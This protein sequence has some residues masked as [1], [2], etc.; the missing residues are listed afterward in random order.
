M[1]ITLYSYREAVS[2]DTHSGTMFISLLGIMS[3]W[4]LSVRED[5][6]ATGIKHYR[7]T[8]KTWGRR[9]EMSSEQEEKVISL[10]KKGLSLRNVS[11]KAGTSKTS[12]DRILKS[13]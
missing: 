6:I 11:E 10:R 5:R 13:A 3:Q 8:H 1:G 9:K 2:T 7:K 4:E 12:V